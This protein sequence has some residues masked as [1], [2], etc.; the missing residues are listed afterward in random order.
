MGAGQL[1]YLDNVNQITS[2]WFGSAKGATMAEH[3]AG[4]VLPG[5]VAEL[6]AKVRRLLL[7]FEASRSEIHDPETGHS[8]Y[9]AKWDMTISSEPDDLD[10]GWI[11]WCEDLPGSIAQGDTEEEALVNLADAISGVIAVRL[12]DAPVN[13][14]VINDVKVTHRQ[15]SIAS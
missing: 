6:M 10:G 13:S 4:R 15:I 1:R 2:M 11:A 8:Q 14:E 7:R 9:T 3:D 12:E 5:A